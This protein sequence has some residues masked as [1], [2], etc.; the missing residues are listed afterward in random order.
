M[1]LIAAHRVRSPGL[2]MADT[3]AATDVS[4]SLERTRRIASGRSRLHFWAAG[5]DLD[6]FERRLRG[7]DSVFGVAHLDDD[8]REERLYSAQVDTAATLTAANDEFDATWLTVQYDDDWWHTESRFPDAD[9]LERYRRWLADRD[10]AV[11]V[12]SVYVEETDGRGPK[13]TRRQRET[14]VLAHEKG[15]YEVPRQA[16]L[17]DLAE[18]FDVSEQAISQRLRR[19]YS[20][21]VAGSYGE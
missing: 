18:E 16:T 9:S 19:A 12:D 8:G 1:S 17:T 15:F 13:L 21:L 2:A 4:V 7:D 11:H 20:R 5:A 14:V 10:A 6:G 3:L